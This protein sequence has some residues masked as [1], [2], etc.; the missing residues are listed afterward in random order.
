MTEKTAHHDLALAGDGIG[1]HG[2]SL[3]NA[4]ARGC[5]ARY[6]VS[7][8]QSP[9]HGHRDLLSTV[10][11]SLSQQRAF[12]TRW[13][14]HRLAHHLDCSA[15]ACIQAWVHI[16]RIYATRPGFVIDEFT[17]HRLLLTR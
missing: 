15:E 14:L 12:P 9:V 6:P 7:F 8:K 16:N 13:R 2:L 10:C 17:I 5:Q 1:A 11:L 4:V 3:A